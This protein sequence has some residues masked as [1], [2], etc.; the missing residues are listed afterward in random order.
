MFCH[1]FGL[2]SYSGTKS[3]QNLLVDVYGGK[4][5][6]GIRISAFAL[7]N[8][9]SFFYGEIYHNEYGKTTTASRSYY[10]EN[11]AMSNLRIASLHI[12]ADFL[13][14]QYYMSSLKG[15]GYAIRCLVR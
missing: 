15:A 5:D 1:P 2:L 11:G 13:G 14:V 9:I 4:D 8:P 3:Y 7:R 10:T 12:H 6:F